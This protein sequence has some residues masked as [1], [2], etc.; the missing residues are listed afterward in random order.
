MVIRVNRMS[1]STIGLNAI[2]KTDKYSNI[3]LLYDANPLAGLYCKSKHSAITK[4]GR[5]SVMG[6]GRT[7]AAIG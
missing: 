6:I 7:V 4:R 3:L 2:L 1:A 5:L